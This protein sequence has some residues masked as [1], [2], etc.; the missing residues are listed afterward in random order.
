[1]L[2]SRPPAFDM[3]ERNAARRLH[4]WLQVQTTPGDSDDALG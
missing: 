1:V 4:E 2:T 3:A